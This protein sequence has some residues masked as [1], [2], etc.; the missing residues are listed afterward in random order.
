MAT[1]NDKVYLVGTTIPYEGQRDIVVYA[2]KETAIEEAEN[3]AKRSCQHSTEDYPII[4]ER[5]DDSVVYV[6]T[7]TVYSDRDVTTKE[8]YDEEF[9]V[10]EVVI[11]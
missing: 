4:Y 3:R 7:F 2:N 9:F 11:H 5:E 10:E 1:I 8:H 6:C